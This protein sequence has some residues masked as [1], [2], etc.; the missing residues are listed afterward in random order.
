MGPGPDGPMGPPPGDMGPG[1]DQWDH[2]PV[3]WQDQDHG[4]RDHLPVI[5]QDQDQ[6]D[7]WDQIHIGDAG[8]AGGPPLGDMPP[9]D[10]MMGPP[11]G[12]M[13]PDGPMGP[14]L[15]MTWHHCNRI[16]MMQPWTSR[17]WTR[18]P[19]PMAW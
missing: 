5:W 4:P 7:Q 10:P 2:L 1:P 13:G 9:G 12:D 19:D 3:I 15:W 14:P 16:W 6:T 18:N 11:P 8:P 17:P